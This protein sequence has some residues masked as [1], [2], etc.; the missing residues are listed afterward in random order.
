MAQP[1]TKTRTLMAK[2]I[3]PVVLAGALL[4]GAV[5]AGTAHAD[6]PVAVT[7]AAPATGAG[8]PASATAA[9]GPKA[10]HA[11]RHWL[12]THRRELRRAVVAIS[13][14]TIGVT[15]QALVAE[16]HSGKSIAAVATEHGKTAQSVVDALKTAADARLDKAVADHKLKAATASKIEAALTAR[17]TKVVNHTF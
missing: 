6:T 13:A 9:T 12:R 2:S 16:L 17:L 3:A 14:K 4:G 8:T 11:L 15:P 10:R 7:A 1:P 5:F